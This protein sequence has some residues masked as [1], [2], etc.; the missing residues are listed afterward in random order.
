MKGLG[1]TAGAQWG[2]SQLQK[3]ICRESCW[4]DFCRGQ[5]MAG[6]GQAGGRSGLVVARGIFP[7]MAQAEAGGCRTHLWLCRH[8]PGCRVRAGQP[9]DICT[10]KK[11][12]GPEQGSARGFAGGLRAARTDLVPQPMSPNPSC[13]GKGSS[14]GGCGEALTSHRNTQKG[15]FLYLPEPRHFWW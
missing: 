2:C 12:P 7:V 14:P 8:S 9:S 15:P 13:P 10:G 4:G 5:G 6:A 1:A 11:H 3:E